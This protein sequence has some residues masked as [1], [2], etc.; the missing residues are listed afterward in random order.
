LCGEG[1]W[2]E[3]AATV[4]GAPRAMGRCMSF[5]VLSLS[6]WVQAKELGPLSTP[7]PSWPGRTARQHGMQ[8]YSTDGVTAV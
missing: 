5:F 8:Y 6:G 4:A 7:F 2:G 3:L 1:G